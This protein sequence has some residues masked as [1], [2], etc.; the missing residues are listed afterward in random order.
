MFQVHLKQRGVLE[1]LYHLVAKAQGRYHMFQVHLK[2][3]GVLEELSHLVAKVP[4]R[5]V[6]KELQCLTGFE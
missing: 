3:R 6:V 4:G 2:Q 5:L 1:E